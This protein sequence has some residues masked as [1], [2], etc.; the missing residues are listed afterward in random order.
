MRAIRKVSGLTLLLRIG[1]LWRCGDGL[2]FEAPLYASDA[3]I[4]AFHPFLE[5]VNVVRR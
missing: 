3:L 5:N 4:T 1:T 2:F